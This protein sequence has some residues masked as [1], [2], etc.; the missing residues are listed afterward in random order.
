MVQLAPGPL[1]SCSVASENGVELYRD[2]KLPNPVMTC[3]HITKRKLAQRQSN[4]NMPV[5]S[6][7]WKLGIVLMARSITPTVLYSDELDILRAPILL[8][9]FRIALPVTTGIG[10]ARQISSSSSM[11]V[12]GSSN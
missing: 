3:S 9:L 8:S 5:E 11:K 12:D 4:N 1:Y 10:P 7:K 6:S 2:G